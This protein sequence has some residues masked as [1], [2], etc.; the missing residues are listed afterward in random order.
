MLLEPGAGWM[1]FYDNCKQYGLTYGLGVAATSWEGV[2]VVTGGGCWCAV[3]TAHFGG[4]VDDDALSDH[5][6]AWCG[7][8]GGRGGC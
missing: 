5:G 2:C 1:G 7:G 8:S 6:A 4:D 3:R